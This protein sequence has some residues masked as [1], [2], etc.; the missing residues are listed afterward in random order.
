[1]R[2]KRYYNRKRKRKRGTGF[3][4]IYQNRVYLGKRPQTGAAAISK[5]IACL[6]ENVEDIIGL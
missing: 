3:P 4:Y 2:R 1:M 6:L 5:V